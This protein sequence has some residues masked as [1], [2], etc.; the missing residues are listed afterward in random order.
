MRGSKTSYNSTGAKTP[1]PLDLNVGF[2]PTTVALLFQ[3]GVTAN[4][5]VQ[6]TVDDVA[7]VPVANMKWF[8]IAALSA[9]TTD[10]LSSV[11]QPVTALRA[12]IASISGGTVELVIIQPGTTTS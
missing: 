9:K 10:T 12:N 5:T 6:C 2:M 3:G 8:D 7:D 1:I 11:D 4:V